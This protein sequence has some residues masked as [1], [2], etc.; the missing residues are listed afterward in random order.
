VEENIL[1]P[2]PNILFLSLRPFF[3]DNY[4]NLCRYT[5]SFCTYFQ[6]CNPY[7]PHATSCISYFMNN[8]S[9]QRSSSEQTVC[10]DLKSSVQDPSR[11]PKSQRG[12]EMSHVLWN[13][14]V[15]YG[16]H[17]NPSVFSILRR[18]QSTPSHSTSLSPLIYVY[19]LQ[20]IC[21]L[22]IPR[23]KRTHLSALC[24]RATWRASLISGEQHKSWS[25]SLC[26]SY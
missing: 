25:S 16:V 7:Y 17:N 22:Q 13:L 12:E 24:K 15:H 2:V 9:S 5:R 6:A 11:A 1:C 10:S 23:Q 14:D 19:V 26:S 4:T 21:F 18:I 20:E 3:W 8:F